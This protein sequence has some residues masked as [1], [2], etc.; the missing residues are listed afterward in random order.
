MATT[1]KSEKLKKKMAMMA[2]EREEFEAQK[3]AMQQDMDYMTAS[4]K[5]DAASGSSS[6]LKVSTVCDSVDE[7]DSYRHTHTGT[8]QHKHQHQSRHVGSRGHRREG[9]RK[10]GAGHG[11]STEE[12]DASGPLLHGHGHA[13]PHSS[14][15]RRRRISSNGSGSGSDN[16]MKMIHAAARN[17]SNTDMPSAMDSP[18]ALPIPSAKKISDWCYTAGPDST[19]PILKGPQDLYVDVRFI[20]RGAFGTVDL[21]KNKED[22]KLYAVKT[23][24][25]K[26]KVDQTEFLHEVKYLRNRH[27][28]IIHLHDVFITTNPKKVYMV[29]HYCE[30]GDLGKVIATAAKSRSHIPE[31]HIYKWFCQ[32]SLAVEFLHDLRIVHRDIKPQNLLLSD[33]GEVALLADFGLATQMEKDD[34]SFEICEVGTPYYTAPEMINAEP[35]SCPVDNWSL[36]VVL[37][38]LIALTMPFDGH[39]TI[40]LVKSILTE[41]YKAALIPPDIYCAD[42]LSVVAGL[43]CKDPAQRMTAGQ[44]LTSP[45][46]TSKAAHIPSSYRPKCLEER[47]KRGHVKQMTRQLGRLGVQCAQSSA[48]STNSYGSTPN[49]SPMNSARGRHEFGLSPVNSMSRRPISPH[50]VS[51][52]PGSSDGYES[53]EAS[54]RLNYESEDVD[55]CMRKPHMKSK[56]ATKNHET[57]QSSTQLNTNTATSGS[58]INNDVAVQSGVGDSVESTASVK[59]TSNDMPLLESSSSAVVKLDEEV[60]THYELIAS[61]K[62]INVT[63]ERNDKVTSESSG[64]MSD[65]PDTCE[66]NVE[67][68]SNALGEVD[69]KVVVDVASDVPDEKDTFE[70]IAEKTTSATSCEVDEKVVVDVASDFPHTLEKNMESTSTA[71]C[72]K[73]DN[74]VAPDVRDNNIVVSSN[75]A[76]A[77]VPPCEEDNRVVDATQVTTKNDRENTSKLCVAETKLPS[78]SIKKCSSRTEVD[79]SVSSEKKQRAAIDTGKTKTRLPAIPH[80]PGHVNFTVVSAHPSRSKVRRHSA[81]HPLHNARQL[82]SGL[83]VSQPTGPA[84][85]RRCKSGTSR[86]V[87]VVFLGDDKSRQSK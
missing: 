9:G 39:D 34:E 25:V 77:I 16:H 55:L 69:E 53:Q 43:L 21:I 40:A 74:N 51:R 66:T 72:K 81:H 75:V 63:V 79:N 56:D 12:G 54:P 52:R 23:L 50:T 10:H 67:T 8:G 60:K 61:T 4:K 27:P 44:I 70:S 11:H 73:D 62:P 38:E 14:S 15:G 22:N 41:E 85:R 58:D 57:V 86:V 30:G 32:I 47:L 7:D 3:R 5:D 65:C 1:T 68:K 76:K 35:C 46:M 80:F 31:S 64:N 84:I 6:S 37:F 26:N 2:R 45:G 42:L 17:A 71:L 78:I 29:M 87:E 59:V 48:N 13:K 82:M 24:L 20:G 19:P 28:F 18:S 49:M 33:S 83:P 36:G